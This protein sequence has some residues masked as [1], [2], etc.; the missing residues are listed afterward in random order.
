MEKYCVAV[1][2]NIRIASLQRH[3]EQE[4]QQRVQR[5]LVADEQVEGDD[6]VAKKQKKLKE[7]RTAIKPNAMNRILGIRRHC[8][9]QQTRVRMKRLQ[10][11]QSEAEIAQSEKA[12]ANAQ[13]NQRSVIDGQEWLRSHDELMEMLM[14]MGI[15][16]TKAAC[17]LHYE[18]I[19]LRRS[20]AEPTD[21]SA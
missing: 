11:G 18:I 4:M 7:P 17:L 14:P 19:I 8:R 12:N 9:S 10:I 16:C 3:R 1:V 21:F 5:G 13:G 15:K 6:E 20:R 2:A